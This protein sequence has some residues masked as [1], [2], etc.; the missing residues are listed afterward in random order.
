LSKTLAKLLNF[1]ID[2][3]ISPNISQLFLSEFTKFVAEQSLIE[4]DL[5]STFFLFTICDVASGSHPQ[6]KLAKFRYK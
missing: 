2:K 3:H 1:I 4:L 5:S 6:E